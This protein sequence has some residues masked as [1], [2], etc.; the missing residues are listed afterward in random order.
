MAQ[1]AFIA[2]L[3][4]MIGALPGLHVADAAWPA[5]KPTDKCTPFN[6]APY[7]TLD[8]VCAVLDGLSNSQ[9]DKLYLGAAKPAAQTG[10]PLRGCTFGCI[11]G[12]GTIEDFARL[13]DINMGWSGKCFN[14]DINSTTGTPKG[15]L[16]AFSP[17]YDYSST[18]QKQRVQGSLAGSA[19]VYWAP[20]SYSD[21]KPV[22][23]FNYTSAESLIDL[24]FKTKVVVDAIRDEIRSISPGF[25]LGRMYVQTGSDSSVEMPIYFALFQACTADG[26]FATTPG[27]RALPALGGLTLPGG[28]VF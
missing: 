1:L 16:N 5:T 15:L 10:F 14:F 13:P 25:M 7:K 19:N 27:A 20:K 22:W 6:P 11:P 9:L 2:A 21:G 12:T 4:L 3:A 26:K 18:P 24:A 17:K 23:T 28:Y 8:T